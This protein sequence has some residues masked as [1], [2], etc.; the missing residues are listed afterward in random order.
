MNLSRSSIFSPTGIERCLF[1]QRGI[2]RETEVSAFMV[3]VSHRIRESS[4]LE[5]GLSS[6]LREICEALAG[7]AGGKGVVSEEQVL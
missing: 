2:P 3:M 6:D 1:R 4:R 5:G 7:M